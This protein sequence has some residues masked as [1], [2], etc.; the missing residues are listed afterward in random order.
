SQFDKVALNKLYLDEKELIT[1]AE[2]VSDSLKQAITLAANNI[3]FF[4]E[5]QVLPIEKNE[6]MPGVICWRKSVAIDKVGLYIPG[7]SAPL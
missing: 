3:R 4:H 6:T 7:G 2:T 1:L 5:K